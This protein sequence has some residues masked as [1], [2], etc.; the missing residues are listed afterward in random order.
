MSTD[1]N[2]RSRFVLPVCAWTIFGLMASL[3]VASASPQTAVAAAN[4]PIV[5]QVAGPQLP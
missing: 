2:L 3:G 1:T 5:A 4:E